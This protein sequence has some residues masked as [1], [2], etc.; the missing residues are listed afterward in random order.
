MDNR[1]TK[2][3]NT[4]RRSIIKTKKV[5][6]FAKPGARI[7]VEYTLNPKKEAVVQDELREEDLS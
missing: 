4:M 2:N 1:D 3:K 6:T 7:L 5:Q